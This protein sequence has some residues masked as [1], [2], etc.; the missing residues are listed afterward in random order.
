[1]KLRRLLALLLVLLGLVPGTGI[2]MVAARPPAGG[3]AGRLRA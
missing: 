1:M 3:G 2:R